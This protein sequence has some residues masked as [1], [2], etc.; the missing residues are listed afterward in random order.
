MRAASLFWIPFFLFFCEAVLGNEVLRTESSWPLDARM[1]PFT[2]A[3]SAPKKDCTDL[4]IYP[5]LNDCF[6]QRW[7]A[8][9][10]FTMIHKDL[11]NEPII[12]EHVALLVHGLSD[13]PY[14]FR[15][16]AQYLFEKGINVIAIRTS[17]H[18]S[19]YRDLQKVH[20]RMWYKD[21]VYGQKEAMRYGRKLILGGMSLGGALISRFLIKKSF[22]VVAALMLSPATGVPDVYKLLCNPLFRD[23]FMGDKVYGKGVRYHRISNNGTCEL[24]DVVADNYAN[25]KNPY[26][27]IEIPLFHVLTQYDQAIRFK[28]VYDLAVRS[29]SY[30]QGKSYIVYYKDQN[31]RLPKEIRKVPKSKVAI[32]EAYRNMAHASVCL[33]NENLWT[34]EG[35]YDYQAVEEM[36]GKF[37]NETLD[38]K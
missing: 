27:D 38:I 19:Y 5:T 2:T 20:R 15:D 24:V 12:T 33:K 31:K 25:S 21:I 28:E 13:S 7:D 32:R 35:N 11:N 36:L 10:P 22:P 14:F 26:K 8:N 30:K 6:M 18:G 1:S 4:A 34:P 29:E 9:L 16:L 17:G 37:L 23:N 3:E